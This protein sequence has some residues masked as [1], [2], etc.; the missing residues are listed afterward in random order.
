MLSKQ[1]KSIGFTVAILG[2]SSV[3]V[4][5]GKN[6]NKINTDGTFETYETVTTREGK[7]EKLLKLVDSKDGV[8]TTYKFNADKSVVQISQAE[9]MVRGKKLLGKKVL[10][11]TC[12]LEANGKVQEA[13]AT[14]NNK[15]GLKISDNQS[16]E[17]IELAKISKENE[18]LL[19]AA[20]E[21]KIQEGCIDQTGAVTL[22][23]DNAETVTVTPDMFEESEVDTQ[24]AQEE[25][26]SEE[27]S[28]VEKEKINIETAKIDSGISSGASKASP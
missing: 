19:K 20:K 28:K 17:N 27:S 13:N 18:E 4:A 11:D 24:M 23:I 9:L 25:N 1:I 22:L 26:S 2:F 14:I 8:Q 6:N 15:D 3:F 12:D 7:T 16:Q 21:G 5:C 10:K